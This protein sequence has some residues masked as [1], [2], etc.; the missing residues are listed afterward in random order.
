MMFTLS[1]LLCFI[2]GACYGYTAQAFINFLCRKIRYYRVRR[3]IRKMVRSGEL[4]PDFKEWYKN[5]GYDCE[6]DKEVK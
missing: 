4:V 3:R 1:L 6:I 5:C 2:K